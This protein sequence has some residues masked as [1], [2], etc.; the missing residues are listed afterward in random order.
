MIDFGTI[1][2][3]T[4]L[5]IP[6]SSFGSTGAS[7]TLTGLS[8][9]D[10]E[11]YKDGSITQR[12]S[13]SGYALL[14]TDG[15]D[16]D[17]IT[18]I[19]GFSVDL[20]DN[21]TAGFYAAG[22]QYFVI[23]SAVTIDSQTVNFIAATFRIGYPDAVLNTTI[24][25]LATQT[26][27]TLTSGPAEDDALNGCQ[28]VVHDV[29]S[30]VQVGR[31]V[32][33][34]YTGSTKTVTLAAG[35]TFTAAATDNVA[36]LGLAPLQPTTAGRTL[37][38]SVGGEAG[39]D[40]ANV[41]TP[42]STVN[43]S[44]TTT[45]LVNTTTTVTNQLTA[46]QIATG[47]WQDTTAGDFTTASSIGKS[48]FTSGVVPGGSGGILISG[49]NSGTTTLGALTV[50][51]ATTLTGN[52][53]MAAGLN[54]TQS[55][56]NTSALVVTGNGTGHG[57][58]ITSGSGATGNGVRIV[59]ASTNG[60]GIQAVGTGSGSGVIMTSGGSGDGLTISSTSGGGA[61]VTGGG[62]SN[63]L[64]IYGGATSGNAVLISAQGGVSGAGVAIMGTGESAGLSIT[65]GDTGNAVT[66]ETVAGHGIVVTA[67]GTSK[68]GVL[69]TGGTAG[70]SDGLKLV[71]GTGGVGFRLD[72]LTASG[73]VAI[74]GA[75][76]VTG[77]FT[78]I[79][80]SN[81]IR[82]I[83]VYDFTTAAKALLQT[84][85]E[86]ALV[87][88]RLDEL[89]NADSD[90]DGLA[91]PTV[92]SVFHELMSKATGSFTFDQT[93]DSLEALRDRG[94][95]AWITATGFSTHTAADV[96][97]AATRVLTAGTNIA[98]AKGVGVTGFNDLSAAQVNTE[99]DTALSDVG[100]TLARMGSLT[101]WIDGGRLDLL[102]DAILADTTNLNDTTLGEIAT[103][104]DAPADATL[105][106]AIRL[107]YQWLRN[108]ST[109]TS[110]ARNV[111]ND[112]GTTVLS[113]ASSDDG[114]TFSPGKLGTP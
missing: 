79:N 89:L 109:Q 60:T 12:A 61:I 38:V 91:P 36:V 35:T 42:S 18:G 80:A 83:A 85:A 1:K 111:K 62:A 27:F 4:T 106:Q 3:G 72:T 73:A 22:S 76:T 113:G 77:A 108:N 90:I 88:H 45:N 50:S 100:V 7:I 21:T 31:A 40:W 8:T 107:V 15:I 81:D 97:A 104:S 24:A 39:I 55:S 28:I 82:G 34:D 33:L 5:Y 101:D 56:V 59:A 32:I 54:I 25:T 47:V 53:A 16:F 110:S 57:A 23:I 65:A 66:I 74:G 51:G 87:T 10:I 112:A 96:W 49:S 63:G 48:L 37:D 94:D 93:T 26:S 95:A 13:D 75:L 114:T 99:A 30:A 102:L 86:D 44:A 17:G 103:A 105:K 64:S 68:H 6:F 29:A 70:T 58:L 46:A 52:V 19:H 71:A 69:I 78:S 67:T 43:L 92:G 41:G 84:E 20:A 98:L 9:A 14:D 11:I 2:P